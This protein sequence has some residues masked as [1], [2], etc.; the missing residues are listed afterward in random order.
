[1]IRVDS[2]RRST[3]FPPSGLAINGAPTGGWWN[4]S[5][6]QRE[7][8]LK[9]LDTVDWK[10]V[11]VIPRL[12]C[13][14]CTASVQVKAILRN[15]RGSAQSVRISGS[16]GSRRLSLGSQGI[17]RNGVKSFATTFRMPNPRVWSPARPYLYNV[18]LRASAGG[19]SVGT[20]RLICNEVAARGYD[21]FALGSGG[22]A[23]AGEFTG[24]ARAAFLDAVSAAAAS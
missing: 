6:L 14:S 8:Y 21:G 18:N 5:G 22:A 13:A 1:M 11:R 20:Y 7:V 23:T 15:V 19:R 17:S 3:D 12:A 4:Y 10:S 9:R 24:V 2:K 16:F